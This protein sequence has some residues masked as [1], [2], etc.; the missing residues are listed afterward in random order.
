MSF[1]HCSN[2]FLALEPL[3]SIASPVTACRLKHS[4]NHIRPHRD[5]PRD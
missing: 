3:A 1:K 4:I 5:K 2:D